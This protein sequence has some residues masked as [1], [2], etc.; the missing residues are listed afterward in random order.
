V[1]LPQVD[2][3]VLWPKRFEITTVG[4]LEPLRVQY[5]VHHPRGRL[6][7]AL[8]GVTVPEFYAQIEPPTLEPAKIRGRV[9]ARIWIA[10]DVTYHASTRVVWIAAPAASWRARATFE[11]ARFR[12]GASWYVRPP[13]LRATA[14]VGAA[15]GGTYTSS[16]EVRRPEPRVSLRTRWSIPIG[17]K[18]KVSPPNLDAAA[19]ARAQIKLDA[20]GRFDHRVGAH[21]GVAVPSIDVKTPSVDV[22]VKVKA[23]GKAA[24][25]AADKAAADAR[26][27]LDVRP[28]TVKVKV[29]APEIKI[30]GEASG[31]AGFKLGT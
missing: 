22:K 11:P 23:S 17:M 28:P 25:D 4:Y 26:A 1:V 30:K 9:E 8:V 2:A 19:K 18:I 21:A 20:N 13:T 10:P 15:I 16:L 31:S 5:Y 6:H 12:G 14:I 27:R 3:A 7:A 29:K 24:V